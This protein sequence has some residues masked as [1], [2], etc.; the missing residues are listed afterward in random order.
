MEYSID[1]LL[2][3]VEKLTRKYTSNES[4]SVTY[5]TARMLM[6]AALYCIEEYCNDGGNELLIVN[7][8]LDA[9]I[10]YQ[11]GYDMVISKVYKTKELYESILEEFQDFQCR[12]CGDTIIKGIPQFF[13]RYDPKFNPQDHILT[14]DYPSIMPINTLCGIDAIYQYLYNIKIEWEF[15]N[16]FDKKGIENFLATIISDY[17]NLFFDNI[18]SS[19]LLTALGCMIAKKPLGTLELQRNDVDIIQSYFEND[20]EEIVE[21]KIRILIST[22]FEHGF[23]GNKTM[24]KYFLNTSKEYSERIFYGIQNHSLSGVFNLI[25]IVS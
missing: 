6:G 18:S 16:V 5:E 1:E 17:K 8:K 20:S 4:S 22:L 15:L 11:N 7:G 10:A 3:V 25:D 21:Q 19:V 23:P 24:E 2:P 12:N 14:L 13:I 9:S